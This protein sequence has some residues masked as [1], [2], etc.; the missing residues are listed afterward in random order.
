MAQ[1]KPAYSITGLHAYPWIS[2]WYAIAAPAAQKSVEEL[3]LQER[4]FLRRGKLTSIALLIELIEMGLQAYPAA[5]DGTASFPALLIAVGAAII[6]T[7]LNRL[8]KLL[9][10][11]WIAMS[12]LELTMTFVLVIPAGGHL[13]VGQLPF[14]FLLIQPLMISVLLFPAG[15]VLIVAAINVCITCFVL[16]VIPKTADLQMYIHMNAGPFFFVPT[17]DLI[18]CALISFIVITSL[19]ENLVRADK[20]EE[21]TKLQRMMAEQTRHELQT[22]RQ[23]ETGVQEIVSGLTHFA[24]GDHTARIKLEQGHLLWPV[25]SSLNNTLGR[26]TRLRE[27]TQTMEQTFTAVQNYLTEVRIA[28]AQGKALP[29]PQSGTQLDALVEEILTYPAHHSKHQPTQRPR[30]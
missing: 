27:Q 10:A 3:T 4:E 18:A 22:K 24:N 19:K 9:P 5:H 20:A 16:L 14:L 7:I 17:S 21:V 26:F 15:G 8:G 12:I 13:S 1:N 29:A 11:G 2:W 30:L 28:K 25:G 6:A 23:L